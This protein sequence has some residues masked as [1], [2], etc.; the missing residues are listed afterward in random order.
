MISYYT[1]K[2]YFTPFW[3]KYV[4]HIY[5]F[6]LLHLPAQFKSFLSSCRGDCVWLPR[7]QSDAQLLSS[8]QNDG[9]FLFSGNYLF[10]C[11]QRRGV[12]TTRAFIT[13]CFSDRLVFIHRFATNT[14]KYKAIIN[15]ASCSFTTETFQKVI[16]FKLYHFLLEKYKLSFISGGVACNLWPYIGL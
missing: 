13:E 11:H 14:Q 2:Y 6:I 10:E 12:N 15:D 8:K 3:P 16:F 5:L 1:L 4:Q 7:L 9:C